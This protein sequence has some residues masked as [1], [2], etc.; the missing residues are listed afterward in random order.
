[1]QFL[2]TSLLRRRRCLIMSVHIITAI[3]VQI[4]G[5]TQIKDGRLKEIIL[6]PLQLDIC[7]VS[8]D[9]I[10][11]HRRELRGWRRVESGEHAAQQASEGT[12]T[13]YMAAAAL[14]P[15][16]VCHSVAARVRGEGSRP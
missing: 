3:V 6:F 5:I 13:R 16:R 9:S 1:M 14:C 4:G 8:L 11:Y 2:A 10:T 12:D 15:P 7:Y